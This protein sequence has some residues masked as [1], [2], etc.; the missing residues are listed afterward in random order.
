M[1]SRFVVLLMVPLLLQCTHATLRYTGEFQTQDGS[2]RGRFTSIQTTSLYGTTVGCALT[3]WIY[4]GFCWAYA[5]VPTGEDKRMVREKTEDALAQALG[6]PVYIP[7]SPLALQEWDESEESVTYY[8]LKDPAPSTA[9]GAGPA[10]EPPTPIEAQLAKK[11]MVERQRE[12]PFKLLYP[13]MT[14][15]GLA[16]EWSSPWNVS[17]EAGAAVHLAR[18]RGLFLEAKY[19]IASS[20]HEVLKVGVA[21]VQL[22]QPQYGNDRKENGYYLTERSAGVMLELESDLMPS[23]QFIYLNRQETQIIEAILNVTY[24]IRL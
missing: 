23:F 12:S 4:G 6:Q 8:L 9:P 10:D 20:H 19:P 13:F 7:L 21:G 1:R 15:I 2:A 3:F 22:E 16:Y 5:M 18:T 11:P 24:R 17:L 14:G